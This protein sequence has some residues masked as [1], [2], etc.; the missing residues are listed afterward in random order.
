MKPEPIQ[1]SLTAPACRMVVCFAWQGDPGEVYPEVR[2]VLAVESRLIS[3]GSGRTGGR[4]VVF[5]VVVTDP[6]L[7]VTTVADLLDYGDGAAEIVPCNWPEAED[8]ERLQPA[9]NRVLH[10]ARPRRRATVPA[11]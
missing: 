11:R 1:S 7:G 2:P 4:R 8:A 9:I 6:D 10:Q 3:E 5:D